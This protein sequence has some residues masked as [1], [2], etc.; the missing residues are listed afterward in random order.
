MMKVV[1]ALAERPNIHES[2]FTG[3]HMFVVWTSSVI[4]TYSIWQSQMSKV[5]AIAEKV[6]PGGDPEWLIPGEVRNEGRNPDCEQ[7]P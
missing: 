6:H 3:A 2:V 7:H 1:V 4:M 5:E